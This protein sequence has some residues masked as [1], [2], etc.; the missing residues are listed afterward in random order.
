MIGKTCTRNHRT[1]VPCSRQDAACVK[2][3]IEDKEQER[4]IKRDLRLEEDRLKRQAAYAQELQEIKDA[5]DHQRRL[6]KYQEEDKQQK[7]TLTQAKADLDALKLTAARVQQQKREEAQRDVAAASQAPA[8]TQQTGVGKA[9]DG[10]SEPD[11]LIPGSA[12]EDWELLKK[13]EDAVSEPLDKL[14]GM[15]GLEEV[16]KE[17]L[18]IKNKV[19]TTLRQGLS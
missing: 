17:F 19:D 16:K 2:C 13:Y 15:I 11:D 3:I 1:R 12:R 8:S 6:I 4:R 18:S 7:K 14:M 10:G 9:K 5:L